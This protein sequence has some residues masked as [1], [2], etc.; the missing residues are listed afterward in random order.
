LRKRGLVELGWL[1][2]RLS[3]VSVFQCE[4]LQASEVCK[5]TE[6]SGGDAAMHWGKAPLL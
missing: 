4:V 6:L 5:H 2:K 3:E 1:W